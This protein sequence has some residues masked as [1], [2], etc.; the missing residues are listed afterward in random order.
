MNLERAIRLAQRIENPAWEFIRNVPHDPLFATTW[1]GKEGEFT[2]T[3]YPRSL[4]DFRDGKYIG[5]RSRATA[6]WTWAI[7]SPESIAYIL[8]VLNG[9]RVVELGAGSGYWAWLLSQCGIKVN[10]YDRAPVGHPESWFSGKVLEELGEDLVPNEWHP[11]QRG[12]VEVLDLTE[13]RSRVLFL[14]WPDYSTPFAY[15]A[16]KAFHGNTVIYIGEGPYGCNAD[17]S[18][19]ELMEGESSWRAE[20]EPEHVPIEQEWRRID[21]GPLTQWAGLHD[22]LVVYERI[23]R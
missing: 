7:P 15:E 11:V 2:P 17:E 6:L 5:Y 4:S 22:N 19:W 12:S 1:D 3:A 21:Y 20:D 8:G 9:R 18:F 10:A 16:V 23:P 14:C 13:N